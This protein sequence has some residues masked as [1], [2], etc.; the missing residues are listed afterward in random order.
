MKVS[1]AVLYER[2]M[3]PPSQPSSLNQQRW[4][5]GILYPPTYEGVERGTERA[6]MHSECLLKPSGESTTV[7]IQLRFL[8]LLSRTTLQMLDRRVAPGSSRNPHKTRISTADES[9]ERSVEIKVLPEDD[10]QQFFQ[11]GFEGLNETNTLRDL[12]RK[13]SAKIKR[14][15]DRLEGTILVAFDLLSAG[16]LKLGIDIENTSPL[17]SGTKNRDA[18]VMSSFLSAHSI[19][20]VEGGEFYSLL[21]PPNELREAAAGCKNVGNF[22]VL[23]GTEGK[24]DMLLCSPT[25]LYDYPQ[26]APEKA[27]NF[28]D[29][30]ELQEMMSLP[31]TCKEQ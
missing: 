8:H 11:F 12:R 7:H 2:H 21:N 10:L 16:V 29:T 4:S 9:V 26:F 23:I 14:H 20:T 1:N 25:R 17:K 3:L 22:P 18:A 31:A 5:S 30:S 6:R 19:L 15:Q 27:G 24:R 28:S 13:P